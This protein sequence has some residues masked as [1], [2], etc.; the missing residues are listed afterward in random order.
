MAFNILKTSKLTTT[1]PAS[2]TQIRSHLITVSS[3]CAIVMTVHPKNWSCITPCKIA[4][5]LRQAT[6]LVLNLFKVAFTIYTFS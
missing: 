2:S 3:R 6:N 4:S 1:L 5:V